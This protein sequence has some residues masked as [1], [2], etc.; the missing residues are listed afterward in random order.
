MLIYN[1]LKTD[2]FYQKCKSVFSISLH[3]RTKLVVTLFNVSYE[4]LRFII[5]Y[6]IIKQ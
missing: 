1:L 3:D 5:F 4:I 6:H 2:F